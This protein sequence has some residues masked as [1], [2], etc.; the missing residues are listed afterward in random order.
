MSSCEPRWRGVLDQRFPV[1]VAWLLRGAGLEVSVGA[2][3]DFARAL[4]CVGLTTSSGVYWAGRA[5][6]VHRPDDITTYD[7]AFD[8]FWKGG[9]TEGVPDEPAPPLTAAF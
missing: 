6:L 4:D 1:A 8:A 7:R 3:L 9:L 5:T 2:T